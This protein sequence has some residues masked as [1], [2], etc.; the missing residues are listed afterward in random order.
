MD[1][2]L[3]SD[4][5]QE[6][7]SS[8]ALAAWELR[9]APLRNVSVPG[10]LVWG[11][12]LQLSTGLEGLV[13]HTRDGAQQALGATAG[14]TGVG[15]IFGAEPYLLGLTA[16]WPLVWSDGIRAERRVMPELYLRWTQAF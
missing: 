2:L 6:T 14:I 7:A 1:A 4:A 16:G 5:C 8:R 11:S 9:T 10:W 13:A 12:E 3:A 15:D